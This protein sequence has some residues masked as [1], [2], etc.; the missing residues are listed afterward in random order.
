[1]GGGRLH[2]FFYGDSFIEKDVAY[3]L[4][5][6]GKIFNESQYVMVG[7]E[8]KKITIPKEYLIPENLT[9]EKMAHEIGFAYGI[10]PEIVYDTK[11]KYDYYLMKLMKLQE[12]VSEMYLQKNLK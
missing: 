3:L 4:R 12:Y 9:Y 5:Q 10:D 7:D 2:G 6:N 8:K 11:T 1:M